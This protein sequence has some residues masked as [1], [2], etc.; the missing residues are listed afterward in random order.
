MEIGQ[1]PEEFW[2]RTLRPELGLIRVDVMPAPDD[3]DEFER[4]LGLTM[5]E[6]DLPEAIVERVRELGR[7]HGYEARV[8]AEDRPETVWSVTLWK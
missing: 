4:L 5:A 7:G 6:P 8:S 2:S 3:P 1:A